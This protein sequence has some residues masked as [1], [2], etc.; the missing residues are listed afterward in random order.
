MINRRQWLLGVPALMSGCVTIHGEDSVIRVSQDITRQD[1]KGDKQVLR[2]DGT[3]ASA[4]RPEANITRQTV[5]HLT[6]QESGFKAWRFGWEHDHNVR[7]VDPLSPIVEVGGFSV[8]GWAT[9]LVKGS[10]VQDY[11]VRRVHF[12][13]SGQPDTIGH[14]E[15]FRGE[16]RFTPVDGP[17]AAAYDYHL[18]S[19]GILLLRS[20]SAF[21]YFPTTS[22]ATRLLPEKWHLAWTQRADIEASRLVVVR[23]HVPQSLEPARYEIGFYDVDKAQ[24]LPTR[25][26]MSLIRGSE[27]SNFR[28]RFYLYDTPKG[29]I[30]VAKEDGIKKVVVRNIR[31][32][33]QRVAF[34][35]DAGISHIKAEQTNTGRITVKV[36]VGFSDETIYDAE[37]FLYNGRLAPP[38]S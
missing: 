21:T 12:I 36:A 7:Y 16:W 11:V 32:G 3:W 10:G 8:T 20:S 19:R 30:T 1:F 18:S 17:T 33:Q 34:S 5:W 4:A 27:E 35:R 38:S 31:T 13:K 37:D 23:R 2:S 24:L 9:Y 28:N 25:L 15:G 26:E 14:L 29:P 22:I 6:A